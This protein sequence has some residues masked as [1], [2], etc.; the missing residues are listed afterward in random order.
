MINRELAARFIAQVTQYTN[1]NV[2]IMNKQGVIIASRDP[3]RVGQFHEIAYRITG[4]EAD[5]VE[6]TKDDNYPG[7]L[8]GI[9]MAIKP[10]NQCEGVVGITGA[11]AEIKSVAL[12]IKMA[13]EVMVKYEKQQKEQLYHTN[14]KEQFLY[15]LI[16]ESYSHSS[17]VRKMAAQLNYSEN[18][19]RIPI[20]LRA[21]KDSA[22]ETLEL[23]KAGKIHQKEDISF[24]LSDQEI[25]IFKILHAKKDDLFAEYK[26]EIKEY[27]SGLPEKSSVYIGSF[28]NNFSQYCY[29]YHHCRW[30]EDRMADK[31]GM[32]FFYD[33]CGNYL[34]EITPDNELQRMFRV[35]GA[36]LPEKFKTEYVEIMESLISS[37]YNLTSAAR[38]LYMHKNTFSY[39]FNKIK[40]KLHLNPILYA[41]DR[42]L[43]EGLYT[44]LKKES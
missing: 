2:N 25:L 16:D 10:D 34:R 44:Y 38:T 39:Q 5:I 17:E 37:N 1:Y 19:V 28:Q 14:R 3:A 4:G 33:Q 20:L 30:L 15:M 42:F 43:M 11:P 7:V 29:A 23:L 13:I 6:I 8:P 12:I 32:W 18:Y 40:E 41:E 27:L 24:V 36:E 26:S 21:E 35:Y 9:N 22:E 31:S